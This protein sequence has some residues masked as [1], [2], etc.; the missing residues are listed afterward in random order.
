MTFKVKLLI[1]YSIKSNVY[2]NLFINEWARKNLGKI[3]EGHKEFLFETLK[4]A[5]KNVNLPASCFSSCKISLS[6]LLK[7]F[8]I[9]Y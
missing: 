5:L 8:S 4:N 2:K 7:L 9:D 3:P 6:I 1:F